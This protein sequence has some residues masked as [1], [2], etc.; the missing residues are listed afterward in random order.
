[1]SENNKQ[2]WN[3]AESARESDL[4]RRGLKA[5]QDTHAPGQSV[6]YLNEGKMR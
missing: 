3:A 2:N 1:M 5:G 4:W 6:Y